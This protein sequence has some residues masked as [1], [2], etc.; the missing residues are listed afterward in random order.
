MAP[1][2]LA[3]LITDL[4]ATGPLTGFEIS[5]RLEQQCGIPL[6]G[7]EGWLYAALIQL[8]REGWVESEWSAAEPGPRRRVYKLPVL[9]PVAEGPS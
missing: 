5:R 3:D 2:T 1:E 9:V 8:E 7:R 4:L 6:S